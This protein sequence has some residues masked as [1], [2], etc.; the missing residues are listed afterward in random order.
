MS[1]VPT[2]KGDGELIPIPAV[3]DQVR[4][5][6]GGYVAVAVIFPTVCWVGAVGGSHAVVLKS[7]PRLD[8][9]A[10]AEAT[11]PRSQITRAKMLLYMYLG[12]NEI[13]CYGIMSK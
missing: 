10:T 8:G 1:I 11:P 13:F 2:P 3:E 5:D 12:M 9:I 7:I 6:P 4:T